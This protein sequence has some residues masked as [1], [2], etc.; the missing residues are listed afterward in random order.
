MQM[1]EL[2]THHFTQKFPHH[3]L[4]HIRQQWILPHISLPIDSLLEEQVTVFHPALILEN[5]KH[6]TVCGVVSCWKFFGKSGKL[7]QQEL[8][9]TKS[10]CIKIVAF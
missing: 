1:H 3:V 7:W 6:Q 9:N 4:Q 2:P 5:K 10:T 8:Q